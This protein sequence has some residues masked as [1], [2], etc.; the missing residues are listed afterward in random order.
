MGVFAYLAFPLWIIGL[1]A[2][3]WCVRDFVVT[4]RGTPAPI[5]PPKALVANGLYRYTRNPMYVAVVTILLGHFF[6]FGTIAMIAYAAIVF[7]AFHSFVMLYEEPHLTRT[8]GASYERYRH[9]VPRG[10]RDGA[11]VFVTLV[12]VNVRGRWRPTR[13]RRSV[14]GSPK[15]SAPECRSRRRS[16]WLTSSSRPAAP[17]TR[18]PPATTAPSPSPASRAPRSFELRAATSLARLWRDQGK[19]AEAFDPLVPVYGTFTGAFT[20][21]DLIDAEALLEKLS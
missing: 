9:V 20:T 18:P 8:F 15:R 4:G 3:L 21:R 11:R 7:L 2:L 17:P 10:S 16:R 12:G 6:W 13:S 19:R 5:D 1:A 14:S